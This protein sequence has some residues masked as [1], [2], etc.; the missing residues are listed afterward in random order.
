MSADGL[1][2]VGSERFTDVVGDA[3]CHGDEFV[4]AV[5]AE[6][7]D[8]GLQEVSVVVEFVAPFE[9]AVAGLLFWSAEV[10]VQVSVVVLG[11]D[12]SLGD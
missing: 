11:R 12:Q 3:A 1:D 9:V 6:S 8:G 10:G 4:L 7:G 2:A 5:S